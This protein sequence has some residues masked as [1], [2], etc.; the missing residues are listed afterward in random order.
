MSNGN[1]KEM[2]RILAVTRR[3]PAALPPEMIGWKTQL[4]EVE[5]MKHTNHYIQGWK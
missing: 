1:G 2:T 5:S 3:E 4:C